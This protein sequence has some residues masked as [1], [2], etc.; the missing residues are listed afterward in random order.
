MGFIGTDF[1]WYD[2]ESDHLDVRIDRFR[3]LVFYSFKIGGHIMKVYYI[4]TFATEDRPQMTCSYDYRQWIEMIRSLKEAGRE[5]NAYSQ[6]Y[7]L[8]QYYE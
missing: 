5:F 6:N 7:V 4:T 2:V 1:L 8:D 3:R